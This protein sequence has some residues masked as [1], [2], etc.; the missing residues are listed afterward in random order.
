MRVGLVLP[1]QHDS[2]VDLLCELHT[3]YNEASSVA[4]AMVRSYLVEDLLAPHS[5]LQLVVAHDELQHVAGFAAIALTYSLVEPHPDRRRHCWLKELYVRAAH[6][7]TGVGEAL[8]AW[9]AQYAVE[10]NCC[11]IDWPVKASNTRGIAFYEGLGGKLL[12][13]RLSYRLE[14]PALTGLATR[15]GSMPD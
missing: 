4:P 5:G 7:G 15:R 6:R 9:V 1:P 14:G 11:R 12:E 13:D 2:L 3:Y 8:M 10:N